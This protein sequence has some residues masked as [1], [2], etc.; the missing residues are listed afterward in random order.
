MLDDAEE[1]AFACELEAALNSA[2]PCCASGLLSLPA[3]ALLLVL[4][5]LSATDLVSCSAVCREL[6][7]ASMEPFLWRR[8]HRTRWAATAGTVEHGG[9]WRALYFESDREDVQSSAGEEAFILR[10]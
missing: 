9:D 8:L 10:L 4:R 6:R 2:S 1:D 3:E 7:A 5:S